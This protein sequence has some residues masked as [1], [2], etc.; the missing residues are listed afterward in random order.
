[1]APFRELLK[2]NQRFYWDST[3]DDLFQKSR[4]DI[5]DKIAEGVKMFEIGRPTCLATDWS[6]TG[7][8]YFLYQNIGRLY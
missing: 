3:L 1:M 4:N 6:K 8:G 2:K 7:V 5:L